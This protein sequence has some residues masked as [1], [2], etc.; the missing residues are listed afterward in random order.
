M[1]LISISTVH[2]HLRGKIEC[3]QIPKPYI[4]CLI[5]NLAPKRSWIFLASCC[6]CC[7]PPLKESSIFCFIGLRSPSGLAGLAFKGAT[8]I[9]LWGILSHLHASCFISSAVLACFAWLLCQ[10]CS[11]AT[12]TPKA[13]PLVSMDCM[14]PPRFS[15]L[16]GCIINSAR[17]TMQEDKGKKQRPPSNMD[18]VSRWCQLGSC[19]NH[20]EAKH[21][22]AM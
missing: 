4:E 13:E 11:Q 8:N 17:W 22:K 3:L 1:R 15:L 19:P 9:K 12:G 21:V 20:S 10:R 2:W 7:P 5:P 14:L 6:Q 16:F 18:Q